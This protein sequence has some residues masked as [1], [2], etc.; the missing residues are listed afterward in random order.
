[1]ESDEVSLSPIRYYL[2]ACLL[3]KSTRDAITADCDTALYIRSCRAPEIC[4][5]GCG[6]YRETVYK[7][8]PSCGNVTTMSSPSA[9]LIPIATNPFAS[10][11]FP[12]YLAVPLKPV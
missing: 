3:G 9:P 11:T 8:A 2:T 10:R 1:M 4:L 6:F 5:I 12:S 7:F